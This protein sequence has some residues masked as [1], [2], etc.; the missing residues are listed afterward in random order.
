MHTLHLDGLLFKRG[1]LHDHYISTTVL[2]SPNNENMLVI[3][4]VYGG[5]ARENKRP[6]IRER[7]THV[8]GC[9]TE[10]SR[11]LKLYIKV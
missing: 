11:R 4:I 2:F 9:N 7:G 6:N 8:K 5:Y 3:D 10:R 1:R